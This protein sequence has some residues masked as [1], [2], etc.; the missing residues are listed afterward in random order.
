MPV[1]IAYYIPDLDRERHYALWDAHNNRIKVEIYRPSKLPHPVNE[2]YWTSIGARVWREIHVEPAGLYEYVVDQM[3][4]LY[5]LSTA[6]PWFENVLTLENLLTGIAVGGIMLLTAGAA[7]SLGPELAAAISAL[8]TELTTIATALHLKTVLQIHNVAMLLSEDYRKFWQDF[9][10]ELAKVS[11]A[12]GYDAYYLALVFRNSRSLIIDSATAMGMSYDEANMV[13]LD[14]FDKYLVTFSKNA[15]KYADNP[16]ALFHDIEQYL[17]KDVV[18]NKTT[19]VA[20]LV[21][22]ISEVALVADATVKDLIIIRKDIDTLI[23]DLPDNISAQILPHVDRFFTGFDDFINDAYY[24]F[25]LD[26]EDR[27]KLFGI[28]LGKGSENIVQMLK[29]LSK[30]ADYLLEIDAMPDK[31]R[32]DQEAKITE[33][34][35][36]SLV[37]ESAAVQVIANPI[38]MELKAIGEALRVTT[39]LPEWSVPE[40]PTPSRPAGVPVEPRITWF[41]GDY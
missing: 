17:E 26:L 30:P 28:E 18:N 27:L 8:S 33:L 10:A 36:R 39:E 14:K 7:A 29:R 16:E 32:L 35:T 20:K 11:K 23:R 19:F 22:S 34:V 21:T 12:L 4:V 5:A 40:I 37:A 38:Y 41:V 6:D 31:Y 15:E 13:W 1:T 25:K 3:N 2:W 24:P 9:Y